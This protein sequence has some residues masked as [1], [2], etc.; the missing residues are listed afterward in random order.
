VKSRRPTPD[1]PPHLGPIVDDVA[2]WQRI[3]SHEL[4]RVLS[5]Y[6]LGVI[7]SMR[8]YP[9]GSRRAPKLR[10]SAERGEFLLK[11]RAPTRKDP[12]R[13]AFAH[14]MQLF[15]A[16]HEFPV[17]RLIGTRHDNNSMLQL[18]GWTYELF[19]FVEGRRHNRSTVQ[20]KASGTTL[21]HLHRLLDDHESEYEPPSGTYHAVEISGPLSQAPAAVV[22]VEPSANESG[23]VASCLT[24]REAYEE[25]VERVTEFGYDQWAP[26]L[27]HGDWHPGNLLFREDAIVAVLDFDSARQEPR[28]IDVANA[29]LQFSMQMDHPDD[30]SSWPTALDAKRIRSLIQGYDVGAQTSL[31]REEREVLPWLMMEALIL[32]SVIPIAANGRF[33]RLPGAAFLEMVVKK[34]DWLRLRTQKLIRYL[35]Q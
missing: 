24:L 7:S 13:V 21:G 25:S 14:G 31:R 19:E 5:H 16:E 9:R 3:E 15:L 35:E 29:A 32:E 27:L 10:I 1:Q 28:I 2:D 12:L 11:R 6:D 17:P 30:P 4:A 22:R 34:V 23:V 26:S 33:A 8:T 20:S 18:D